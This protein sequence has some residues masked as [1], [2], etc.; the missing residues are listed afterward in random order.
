MKET[1]KLKARGPAHLKGVLN[2]ADNTYVLI[3]NIYSKLLY[4]FC[5][6]QQAYFFAWRNTGLKRENRKLNRYLGP[7][8]GRVGCGTMC[9]CKLAEERGEEKRGLPAGSR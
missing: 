5:L 9:L 4:C 7:E 8:R 1:F 3:K 2:S 6:L